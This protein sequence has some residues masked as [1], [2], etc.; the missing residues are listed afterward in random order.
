MRKILII[1][2]TSA[3]AEATARIYAERGD[4]LHLVARDE[5]KLEAIAADLRVRGAAQVSHT[6]LDVSDYPRHEAVID[7]SWGVLEGCDLVL[8]AHGTLPNQAESEA[9]WGQTMEALHIN[10]LSVISL[11]TLLANRFEAQGSG[12]IA[13]IGSVAADRIRRSNFT[14]GTAKL[15]VTG[16]L[17]GLRLRLAPAGIKVLTIKPGFVDTPMTADFPKGALWAKPADVAKGI[18]SAVEKGRDSIYLPWFWWGIMFIIRWLPGP[19]FR[20]LKI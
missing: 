18:V 2:A 11:L 20:R 16:F 10:G 5:G 14:Y 7:E 3:I 1:G 9:D 13:V 12:T 4:R 17:E 6:R 15:A 8:I 19:I